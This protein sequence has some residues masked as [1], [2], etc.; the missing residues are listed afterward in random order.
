MVYLLGHTSGTTESSIEVV[1]HVALVSFPRCHH[2]FGINLGLGGL[3][4]YVRV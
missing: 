2:G 3:F 4:L 1:C